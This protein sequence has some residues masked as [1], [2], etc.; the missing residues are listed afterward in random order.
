MRDKELYQHILGLHQ[1]WA[2]ADVQLDTANEQIIIDV[3]H[4][5]GTKFCCPQYDKP[6]SCYDY[7]AAH[8][9][10]H[11]DSCQYRTILRASVPRVKCSEHGVK[12]VEVPWA[13]AGSRFTL[14][15]EAFAIDLLQ[16]T[17][18]V[19]GARKIL[20]TGWDQTWN[21]VV[22]TIQRGKLR[23]ED[24]PMPRVGIDEKSFA[25]GQSYLTL[26]YDLD[27]STVEAISEGNNTAS[28]DDCFSKL[29]STQ[30]DS[31]EAIAMD[32]SAA[33]VRSAKANIPLAEEK[34]VHDRFHVMKLATEAVDKVRCQENRELKQEND[35]RLTGT[36]FLWIK[37]QENFNDKQRT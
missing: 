29:S 32:M 8:Q 20:R 27:R 3:Y 34:I 30:T 6:L 10:R 17:Q 1:P 7:Y 15:F 35:D 25:K 23:K 26:L 14:M 21:I 11:L 37:S 2:V 18:N 12:Q 36:R 24:L 19:E 31:I 13:E 16:A 28:A 5:R 9:W 4:P 22:R 33:Y